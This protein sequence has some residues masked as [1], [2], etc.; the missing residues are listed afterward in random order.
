LR[1]VARFNPDFVRKI[2][3]EGG[4]AALSRREALKHL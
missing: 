4:I 2:A 1:T 3:E